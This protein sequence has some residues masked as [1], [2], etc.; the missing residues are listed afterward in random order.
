MKHT[1]EMSRRVFLKSSAAVAG[2]ALVGSALSDDANA[3]GIS[4]QYKGLS[5]D[6]FLGKV[7]IE[8]EIKD[9][10]VF[11]EG[12]AVDRAGNVFFTNVPVEKIL[13]LKSSSS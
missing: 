6:E 10:T 9:Q 3:G 11:T 5:S 2:G 1:N 12:P 8:T 4:K 13:S 7:T